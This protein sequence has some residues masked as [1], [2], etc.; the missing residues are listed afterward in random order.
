MYGRAKGANQ[1]NQNWRNTNNNNWNRPQGGQ[2]Q[3]QRSDGYRPNYQD[4]RRPYNSSNAPRAYNDRTVPMDIGRGRFR[5]QDTQGNAARTE[6]APRGNCYNCQKPGHYA[7][8]CPEKPRPRRTQARR[9]EVSEERYDDIGDFLE[10]SD[11]EGTDKHIRSFNQLS[12][13]EKRE[14]VRKIDAEHSEDFP[15]A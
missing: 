12:L 8:E 10:E 1:N 7:R 3:R 11:E 6:N 4:S 5:R 9:S 15:S 13:K 14:M 2:Q